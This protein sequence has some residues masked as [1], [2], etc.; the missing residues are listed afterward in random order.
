MSAAASWAV[1][2]CTALEPQAPPLSLEQPY[3]V[4]EESLVEEMF[5]DPTD[6]SKTPVSIAQIEITFP[7]RGFDGTLKVGHGR[8]FL[9]NI[10]EPPE[11]GLPLAI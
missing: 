3:A 6:G 5:S 7:Y 10:A 2:C 4:E 11:G 1:A 8:L 9:P